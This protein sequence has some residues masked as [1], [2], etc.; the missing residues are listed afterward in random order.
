[1]SY[2]MNSWP[3]WCVDIVGYVG[4]AHYHSP[5]NG[6]TRITKIACVCPHCESDEHNE[7]DCLNGE[8]CLGKCNV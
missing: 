2:D 8:E 4:G 5:A 6:C 7:E 1:M 3:I